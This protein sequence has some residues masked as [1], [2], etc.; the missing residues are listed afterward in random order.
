M[1]C[2]AQ[3]NRQRSLTPPLA[4]GGLLWWRD[5]RPFH[6]PCRAPATALFGVFRCAAASSYTRPPPPPPATDY[7]CSD[8]CYRLSL[9]LVGV[10]LL[11]SVRAILHACSPLLA[12][13]LH[14][15]HPPPAGCSCHR[16][17]CL[18]PVP[19]FLRAS[20]SAAA[21]FA[22]AVLWRWGFFISFLLSCGIKVKAIS[23]TAAA[24]P[25]FCA[26]V[27]RILR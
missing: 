14:S 7:S 9:Q 25:L 20:C 27:T 19:I 13:F 17:R 5:R 15:P 6:R 8:Y 16:H 11:L 1:L 12:S 2:V 23:G 18:R 22:G 4:G 3:I 24:A 26:L 21:R 10:V